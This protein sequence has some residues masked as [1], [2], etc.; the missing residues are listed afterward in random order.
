M[1]VTAWIFLA[2]AVDAAA[3]IHD[4]QIHEISGKTMGTFYHVKIAHP[5][6]I[7]RVLL[8]NKIDA[9]LQAVNNSMSMYQ[10]TSEISRFNRSPEN[11]PMEISDGF[12]LVLK[13]ARALYDLTGGAWDGTIKPLVDIWGF[14][15]TQAGGKMPT[16]STIENALANTGFDKIIL[17]EKTLA[18]KKSGI[19]LDMGSIAK[20][21]GVDQISELLRENHFKNTLVEIGGEVVGSGEKKPGKPWNVGITTPDKRLD[22][23]TV[24]Q[25]IALKN[26]A[27]ATSGDYR[28]FIM[29]DKQAY[30]HIIDPSTGYPVKNGVV[31]ASVLAATCTLADGLATALMVMGPK[32]AIALVNRMAN[33]ECLIIVQENDGTFSDR[34]STGFPVQKK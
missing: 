10:K 8:K 27:L 2:T 19:T 31:S 7:D 4:M 17:V 16:K 5:G 9:R 34:Y 23:Q 22:K 20:G 13:E 12:F 18:K 24:Y 32:K 21:Y 11:T 6:K 1:I 25:A 14:G 33:T 3:G 29:L 28:N 26:R 15:T 30:S